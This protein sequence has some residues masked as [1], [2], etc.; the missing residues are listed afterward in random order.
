MMALFAGVGRAPIAV[1]LMVSEM[2]G[3][4]AL[5]APS[6]VAVILAYY[7]TGPN[8]TI[9]R[10]QVLRRSESPAH[11]GE[12]NV[13]LLMRIRVSDA[14]NSNV[15]SMSPLDTAQ[16]AYLTMLERGFKGVPIV[17]SGKV[18][19]IVSLGDVLKIAR[20]KM[21]STSLAEV[22]TAD[23]VVAYPQEALLEVLNKLTNHGIG[24]LP[25][26]SKESGQLLGIIT[27]TDAMRAYD[28]VL[29]TI[30]ESIKG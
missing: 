22:M 26:V 12:Y 2:T 29:E 9:Y 13:P 11:R 4:L 7:V 6:M 19:G 30:A 18:V 8:Y 24:R 27:M 23:P 20:E 25:V 28:R 3:T 15:I 17:D 10:S 1:I 21:A 5:L 16:K 14:M